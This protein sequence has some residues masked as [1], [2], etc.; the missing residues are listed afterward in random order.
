MNLKNC[1]QKEFIGQL[2]GR[3]IICFGAGAV[4]LDEEIPIE[5]LE[6]HIAFFVDNDSNKWGA[7]ILLDGKKFSV[8]SPEALKQI[9]K[10]EY[11]VMITCMAYTPIYEQLQSIPELSDVDCYM[12]NAVINDTNVDLTNY[13]HKEI[14]KSAYVDYQNIL[15]SLKL[16]KKH[17]GKRCF[18]VGN[19]PSL[20]LEDLER[21]KDEVTFAFNRINL[22]FDKTTWRPSYYICIDYYMHEL[23]M[24]DTKSEISYK[25]TPLD[26]TFASGHVEDSGVFYYNRVTNYTVMENGEV[27]KRTEYPFSDNVIEVVYGGHT[28][29]YDALQF[30]IY[31]GF[32]DIYLIGMDHSFTKEIKKNGEIV[33]NKGITD[34]FCK[35]YDNKPIQAAPL[36]NVED[37][38]RSAKRYAESQGVHIYNATRGGR[39]EIFKRIDFDS[40]F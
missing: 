37:S 16:E 32:T 40:L 6:Q 38:L 4:I 25:F 8:K 22:L 9:N 10:Y 24:Q 27:Q 39:L 7:S 35:E 33:I 34:H 3:K 28:V 2:K 12:Y 30:A 29:T 23:A 20:Q 26:K 36:D 21:L 1:K 17:A 5:K 19:G 13:F 15:R 18:I 14:K 11:C 31:M